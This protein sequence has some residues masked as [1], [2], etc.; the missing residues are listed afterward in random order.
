[1]TVKLRRFLYI[2][3]SVKRYKRRQFSVYLFD[4]KVLSRYNPRKQMLNT[5][6]TLS[7]G[8]EKR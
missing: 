1:M 2:P 8:L 6:V 4:F 5:D 3:Q 7:G